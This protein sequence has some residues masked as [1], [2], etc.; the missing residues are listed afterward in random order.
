VKYVSLGSL[1]FTQYVPIGFFAVALPTILRQQGGSLEAVGALSLLMVPWTL[2]VFWSPVVD[3]YGAARFGHYR[4]WIVPLQLSMAAA[5]GAAASFDPVGDFDVLLAI[6]LLISV[7]SATQDIATDALAVNLLDKEE[8]GFGNGLQSAGNYAGSIAGGGALLISYDRAGWTASLLLLAL[9][10]ALPL[11]AVLRIAESRR[12]DMNWSNQWRALGYLVSDREMVRWLLLA[13]TSIVGVTVC[14]TMLRPFLV[15]REISLQEIGLLTGV[16]W[17][18]A[19]LLGGLTGGL[20]IRRLGRKRALVT[21]NVCV[22]VGLTCLL[23]PALGFGGT[24]ALYLAC[25]AGGFPAGAAFVAFLTVAMDRSR[26]RTAGTD[27]TV[28]VA[29][30]MLGGI[31]ASTASGYLASRLG[32]AATFGVGAAASLVSAGLLAAFFREDERQRARCVV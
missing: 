8:R 19:G 24:A 12:D 32:Y 15:D 30:L 17:W 3:R 27:Y 18:T 9:I 11:L 20:L 5:T 25:V 26:P 10:L 28:Q 1:W 22:A 31:L 29:V 4:S 13:S 2:K 16:L 23:V 14:N 21:F 7:L 6:F